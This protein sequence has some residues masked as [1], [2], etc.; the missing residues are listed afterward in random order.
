MSKSQT[1]RA[2][3]NERL[4]AAAEE[5]FGLFERTIAEYEE[6]VCRSKEE[7]QRKQELLDSVLSPRVVLLRAGVQIPSKSPG[8]GLNQDPP[9]TPRVKEEPEEP[10]VKQEEH[11]LLVQVTMGVPESSAACATTE[12]SSLLQQRQTELRE[13][14]EGEDIS[15]ETHLHSSDTV[16]DENWGTLFICSAAQMETD[17]DGDHDNQVQ[18]DQTLTT[19]LNEWLSVTA[20]ET[21]LNQDSPQTSQIKDAPEEL[22]V[23]QEEQLV[24]ES[25]QPEVGEDKQTEI[26]GANQTEMDACNQ[27][28]TGP[29][30][31]PLSQDEKIMTESNQP[32][33]D[34]GNQS[35]KSPD[36]VHSEVGQISDAD[37]NLSDEEYIPDSKSQEDNDS[38]IGIPF[39]P[40]QSRDGQVTEKNFMPEEGTS[41]RL[42]ADIQV[43]P[44]T[45]KVS[46]PLEDHVVSNNTKTSHSSTST[47][48]TPKENPKDEEQLPNHDSTQLTMTIKNYCY[49]CGKPQS[50]ISRHLRTHTTHD[51]VLHVF[52]LP[53]HSKERKRL[54]ERMR[55]KGNF[56][57]YT[58]VLQ[59]ASGPVKVKRKPKTKE[60]SGKFIHCMHCQGMFIRKELW[61]HVRKCPCKPDNEI[62]DKAPG[63][64]KVLG[65]AGTLETVSSH[66]ISS[67]VWK[68][69]TAMKQDE[70]A[71]VVRN[72]LSIIQFAQ[73]LYN[74]H[75]QDPTK[76]EYMRQQLREVGR[77]L[78]C[79]R[80]EFSIHNL[81][82]AVKPVNFQRVVQA[83]KKVAGFDEEKQLYGTPSL[84]LKLGHTLKKICD[85]IHCRAL[86]VEDEELCKSTDRFKKLYAS[87]WSELVPHSALNTLSDAKYNKPSTLLFTEDVQI[88]HQY[89][90]KSCRK[91]LFQLEGSD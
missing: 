90:E 31:D 79:L 25:N 47:K 60:I 45:S 80:T 43:E 56:R 7:N 19:L 85:I 46:P 69:L 89:L 91:C 72:D 59:G 61:R 6:E 54:L 15:A 78:L 88:L 29:D 63:R 75:G 39:I 57:H 73:F 32:E 11:T 76:R 3:V 77:L 20:E 42:D 41:H 44:T 83:V 71:S 28:L 23:K 86:V 51:E 22:S 68:L 30:H 21:G 14:T 13:E 16:N 53:D 87:K 58:A 33:I 36:R 24:V 62:T 81:E 66:Q 38:D 50:K 64:T 74:R 1:L 5:I 27:S 65:V 35:L 37:D 55:N 9:Q 49:I 48:G 12:E 52:S 70:V 18:K 17:A 26:D 2:L 34:E 67:G 8:P 10:S 40:N 84:A 82:E 4:T